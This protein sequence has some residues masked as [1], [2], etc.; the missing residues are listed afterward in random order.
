MIGT[1]SLIARLHRFEIVAV[2]LGAAALTLLALYGVQSLTDIGVPERCFQVD[3][4]EATPGCGGVA[5]FFALNANVASKGFVG[6]LVAPYLIGV[7]LGVPLVAT[8]I[9]RRTA[10]FVWSVTPS[11]TRWFIGRFIFVSLVAATAALP[12]AVAADVLERVSF[13]QFQAASSFHNYGLRGPL[14]VG[15][16]AAALSVA[17][18]VGIVVGRVLPGLIVAGGLCL[19]LVLAPP[20]VR[21]YLAPVDVLDPQ[22][23]YSD[24]MPL[25]AGYRR[26]DGQL[27]TLAEAAASSPFPIGS[28]QQQE[29]VN[30]NLDLVVFGY[31]PARYETVMLRET[32]LLLVLAGVLT[33]ASVMVI[34]R[35]RPY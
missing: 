20:L 23:V 29:W 13:P 32:A 5:E 1:W 33:L 10:M 2:L 25:G 22:Q 21:P 35:R 3:D 9:E 19:V 18:L 30:Q 8:M 14:L 17:V 12:L 15:S 31:R 11:R 24:S 26:P 16:T 6:M 4:S 28:A 7:I 27:L 34:R